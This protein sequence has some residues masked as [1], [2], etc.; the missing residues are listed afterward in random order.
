MAAL[1]MDPTDLALC[2]LLLE[3]SRIP[4]RELADKLGLSVAAVHARIQGL[5]DE[6]IIKAFTARIGLAPLG[7]TTVLVWGISRAVSSERLVEQ[8]RRD[9]HVY[10]VAFGGAGLVY[11][12]TYLRSAAELD[13]IVSFVAKEAE[14]SDPTVGIL[15][16]GGGLPEKPILDRTDS[17]ILR[18]L[19]RDARKSIADVA[20]ELGLSAKTVGRRLGRMTAQGSAELSMEWYP[21]AANDVISMWHLD[22][23]PSATREEALALLANRYGPNLLFTMPLSNLPRFVLAATWTGSMKELKD[24]Q[25]R[26]GREKLFAR[27]VPNI[28][29]TGRILDTWRDELLMKWAGPKDASA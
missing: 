12:G 26:M 27:V 18:S 21:D 28:L 20:E 25:A 4:I 23:G 29:Y 10:W 7:V 14:I 17:R 15:P 9:G 8:L 2:K 11:V 6:G 3:N 22:L 24:L 1:P 19:H 13:G 16:A 5:R